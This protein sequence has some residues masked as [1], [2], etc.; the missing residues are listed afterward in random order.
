L[1]VNDETGQTRS[2]LLFDGKFTLS[3]GY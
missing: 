1:K 2:A 3:S